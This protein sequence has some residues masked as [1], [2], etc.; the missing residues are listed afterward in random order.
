MSTTIIEQ[1]DLAP[2]LAQRRRDA[3]TDVTENL[4]APSR[5]DADS[6]QKCRVPLPQAAEDGTRQFRDAAMLGA[7]HSLGGRVWVSLP[8]RR[9]EDATASGT[10][11]DQVALAA[12]SRG[13]T[14]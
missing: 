7:V 14:A 3:R 5:A 11:R 2:G 1:I 8:S 4:V 9:H 10:Y 12:A 6:R 13:V